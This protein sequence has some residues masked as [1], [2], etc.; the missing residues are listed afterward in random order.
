VRLSQQAAP[1]P[2]KLPVLDVL[3]VLPV[4]DVLPVLEVL[5]RLRSGVAAARSAVIMVGRVITDDRAGG[6]APGMP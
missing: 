6:H 4:L 2:R 3:E 5:A 1:H